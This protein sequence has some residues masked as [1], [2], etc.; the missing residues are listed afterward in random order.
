MK[1]RNHHGNLTVTKVAAMQCCYSNRMQSLHALPGAGRFSNGE[2]SPVAVL[3]RISS[4]EGQ[5][6]R[7][8]L[9]LSISEFLHQ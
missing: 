1:V 6:M 2:M 8:L 7:P 5:N 3:R 9:V 4:R